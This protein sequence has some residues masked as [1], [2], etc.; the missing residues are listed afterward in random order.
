MLFFPYMVFEQQLSSWD[1][2]SYPVTAIFANTSASFQSVFNKSLLL[3]IPPE[4]MMIGAQLSRNNLAAY[5]AIVNH[6]FQE[7]KY[8]QISQ[9]YDSYDDNPR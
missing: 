7:Q 3:R 2:Y 1:Q 6:G 8:N 4:K 9:V 5:S